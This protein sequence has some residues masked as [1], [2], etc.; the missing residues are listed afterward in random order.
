MQQPA[1]VKNMSEQNISQTDKTGH[2]AACKQRTNESVQLS[3][4]ITFATFLKVHCF[5]QKT[6][7]VTFSPQ[8]NYT[9]RPPLVNKI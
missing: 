8:A 3:T 9:E 2:K 4:N 5:S 6:N 7:S 1:N